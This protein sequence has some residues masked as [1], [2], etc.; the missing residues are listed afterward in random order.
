MSQNL[1]LHTYSQQVYHGWSCF[2][3]AQSVSNI[4]K[5]D[6]RDVIF[7]I[8]STNVIYWVHN[9]Y[10]LNLLNKRHSK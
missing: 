4:M 5:V 6:L 2:V 9:Q 3:L 8:N 1:K 7:W 10:I